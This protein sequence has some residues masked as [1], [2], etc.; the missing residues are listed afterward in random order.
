MQ[1]YFMASHKF[2]KKLSDHTTINFF[3]PIAL[4]LDDL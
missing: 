1:S 2:I 4:V 3:L